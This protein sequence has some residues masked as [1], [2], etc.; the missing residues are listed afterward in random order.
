M[1]R[2]RTR[3]GHRQAGG[4]ESINCSRYVELSAE[5]Q[6]HAGATAIAEALVGKADDSGPPDLVEDGE[7]RLGFSGARC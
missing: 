4:V 3:G 7:H 2:D 6:H 5:A 1:L